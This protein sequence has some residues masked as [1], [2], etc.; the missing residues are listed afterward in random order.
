M[1]KPLSERLE[2]ILYSSQMEE[3]YFNDTYTGII[4]L[5]K[6]V[7]EDES[8]KKQLYEIGKEDKINISQEESLE[9]TLKHI[10]KVHEKRFGLE[11]TLKYIL[12]DAQVPETE[13]NKTFNNIVDVMKKIALD[14]D[15]AS[16]LYKINLDNYNDDEDR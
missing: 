4:Y 14:K 9:D 10:K 12:W 5:M 8:Y 7:V 11:N 1:E 16:E 6:N 13:F 3:Y 2:E 15:Y